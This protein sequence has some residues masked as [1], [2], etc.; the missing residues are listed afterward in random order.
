[1]PTKHSTYEF[2]ENDD[3]RIARLKGLSLPPLWCAPKEY[4]VGCHRI[5]PDC[6]EERRQDIRKSGKDEVARLATMN[7]IWQQWEKL[8]SKESDVERAERKQRDEEMLE[9]RS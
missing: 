6:R 2:S 1:M 9:M 3:E 5:F 4:I 8:K 7:G